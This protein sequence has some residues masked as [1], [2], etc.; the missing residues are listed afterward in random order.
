L[1]V[2]CNII[3]MVPDVASILRRR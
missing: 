3:G 1:I 2:V